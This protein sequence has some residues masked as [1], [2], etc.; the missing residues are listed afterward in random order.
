MGKFCVSPSM[1]LVIMVHPSVV[2]N[3]E[4]VF[5]ELLRSSVRRGFM[6]T[7][8]VSATPPSEALSSLLPHL[9]ADGCTCV[10]NA[11]LDVTPLRGDHL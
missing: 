6:T 7:G 8:L 4:F 10:Q 3:K 9:L 2:D 1:V 11:C 5:L